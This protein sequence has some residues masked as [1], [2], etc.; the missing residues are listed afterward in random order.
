[1]SDGHNIEMWT[2]GSRE[3]PDRDYHT[4][5]H[6]ELNFEQTNNKKEHFLMFSQVDEILREWMLM[7]ES[8]AST[9][10]VC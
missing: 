1:M 2:V 6:F 9:C 8:K 5:K 7:C 3:P 10:R 4:E